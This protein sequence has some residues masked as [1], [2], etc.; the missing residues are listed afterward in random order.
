MLIARAE[1]VVHGESPH[2]VG[3]LEASGLVVVAL[4]SLVTIPTTIASDILVVDAVVRLLV[5]VNTARH[6]GAGLVV[7]VEHH[8]LVDFPRAN[9]HG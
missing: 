1:E 7:H 5:E 8:L 2:S 4:G 3:A 6:A 9:E